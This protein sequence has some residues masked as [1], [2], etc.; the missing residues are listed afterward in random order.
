MTIT[1]LKAGLQTTLQGRPRSGY[2]HF[3][4][5]SAGPAD[6]LSM[7]LANRLV[8]N[9]P[10]Q[11][12]LEVTLTGARFLISEPLVFAVTGAEAD[13]RLNHSH[14]PLHESRFAE[15]GDE[16][17][18]GPTKAGCRNYLAISADIVADEFLGSTSTYLPGGFG[19]MEGRALRDGDE[20]TLAHITLPD[21]LETPNELRPLF[22]DNTILQVV[23]GPDFDLLA[24][25]ARLFDEVFRVTQRTSRMGCQLKGNEPLKTHD[26]SALESAAVFPGT[27]Q[28][29]PDGMPFLLSADA[30]TTGGYPHILQIMRTDR[31]QLGQL[32]PGGQVRF[33]ERDISF[34]NE[35]YRQRWSAYSD[36]LETPFI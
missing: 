29:P 21:E 23:K 7:S 33:V 24:D 27:I 34:A 10:D 3:G 28:C 2:R 32:R 35:S 17:S 8:G 16:L 36:W 22:N 30:Q 25:Q 13:I 4:V 12:A 9:R 11:T 5:P 20:L 18:I 31:F 26:S 14:I 15:P 1:V 19:G 6:P